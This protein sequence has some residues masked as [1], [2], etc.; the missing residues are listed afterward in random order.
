[1][2]DPLPNFVCFSICLVKTTQ[3]RYIMNDPFLMLTKFL[4]MLTKFG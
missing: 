4:L 1:M 2:T 3:I